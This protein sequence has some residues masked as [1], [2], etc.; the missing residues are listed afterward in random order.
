MLREHRREQRDHGSRQLLF[1]NVTK[2]VNGGWVRWSNTR[3]NY[4]YMYLKF[5]HAVSRFPQLLC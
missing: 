2:R 1:A 4:M 3:N 5:S